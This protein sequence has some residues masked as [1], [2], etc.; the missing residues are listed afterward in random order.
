[1]AL[2]SSGVACVSEQRGEG[3][4]SAGSPIE[5]AEGIGGARDEY[6]VR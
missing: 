1:M 6:A 3:T 2:L 4:P 5:R